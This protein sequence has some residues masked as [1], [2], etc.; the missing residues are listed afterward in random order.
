MI[1]L[2]IKNPTRT[3]LLQ[4]CYEEKTSYEKNTVAYYL[5]GFDGKY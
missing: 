2:Q 5:F 4:I 1:Q 3:F